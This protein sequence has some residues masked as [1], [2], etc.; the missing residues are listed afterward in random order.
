MGITFYFDWEVIFME[1]L[2]NILGEAGATAGSIISYFGEEI[3]LIAVL[4][5]VY[6]CFDKE[7]GRILG[8]S[9]CM[10]L[11]ANPMIKNVFL[12][13]RPYF[14]NPG[15]KCFKPVD[16]EADIYDISAQGFSFPSGHSTSAAIVYGGLATQYK[17]WVFKLIGIAVPI[18]VALSR[19]AVGV[20][21]PTDVLTG[22][23][24]GI[25]VLFGSTFLYRSVK[26]KWIL[27]LSV[28]VVSALGII[29]CRSNDYYTA[30]GVMGGF[31]AGDLFEEKY[32]KFENTKSPLKCFVRVVCGTSIFMCL[33][34]LL[35]LPF[36][37]EFLHSATMAAYLVRT[38]R[39]FV[40]TF[41]VVGLYPILFVKIKKVF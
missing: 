14:D 11:V 21:Y 31:F 19:M 27:Y 22:L 32:V 4:S 5:L 24:L 29:Y 6:W 1:W 17:D 10:G 13:R 3:V 39:Y 38:V 25:A 28:F 34:V 7:R 36:S 8:L 16:P 23:L 33:N 41:T 12:R 9:I 30:L 2:Q 26:R 37:D 35:K 18:L 40:L 15:I 20:H